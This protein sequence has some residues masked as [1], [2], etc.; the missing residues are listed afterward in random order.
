MSKPAPERTM[1]LCKFSDGK[2]RQILIDKKTEPLIL[3][4][5]AKVEGSISVREQPIESIEV[6]TNELCP[7]C[8]K[9]LNDNCDCMKNLCRKCD[10][11]VGNITFTV[12]D[13]CWDSNETDK[14]LRK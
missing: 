6:D 2:I 11:P 14:A 12:C 8:K 1:V 7:N 10:N 13:E 5:I 9:E 4:V 3:E